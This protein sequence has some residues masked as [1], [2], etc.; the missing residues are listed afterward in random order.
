MNSNI[1]YYNQNILENEYDLKTRF[2]TKEATDLGSN[3]D[4]FVIKE[5]NLKNVKKISIFE[6]NLHFPEGVDHV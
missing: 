3:I 4:Y 6:K 5:H 2:Q 1:L